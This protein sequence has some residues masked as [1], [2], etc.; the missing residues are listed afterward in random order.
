MNY[1]IANDGN[2]TAVV[3]GEVFTF[4]ESHPPYDRF[5]THL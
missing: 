3:A 2:V 4:R 5:I 1:L